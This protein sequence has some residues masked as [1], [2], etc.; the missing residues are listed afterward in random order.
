MSTTEIRKRL[1]EKY[2][3]FVELF[4]RL[5][6]SRNKN[7]LLKDAYGFLVC[8][9]VEVKSGQEFTP[10]D[11]LLKSRRGEVEIYKTDDAIDALSYVLGMYGRVDIQAIC[12]I[13]DRDEAEIIKEIEPLIYLDPVTESWQTASQF[14]SGNVYQ[15]MLIAESR[16]GE[17]EQLLRSYEAIKE[18]QV[19]QIPWNLLTLQLGERWISN[20]H[21]KR[22][23]DW[24]FD[25]S[26]M[27]VS[28]FSSTDTY[29]VVS[30]GS[31]GAKISREYYVMSKGRTSLYGNDL[32]EYALHNTT[33]KLTYSVNGENVPDNDAI[34]LANE[35]IEDLRNK[36]MEWLELLKEE[37]KQ[38]LVD[39]Y[40]NL[41]NCYVIRKY[42]GS[43]LTL[44]GID[45]E[46]LATMGVKEI[47][48]PQ[49]DVAWRIIQ[50][51]GA[52][53]DW[54][55][56]S[57]K[58]ICIVLAAHE[59]KRM[60]IRRKPCI[61]CLKANVADIVRTYRTAYPSAKVLAPSEQDFE[62][63]NRVRLF[64]EMKNNDWD[65][66]IMTHDQ[67][68]RIPQSAEIQEEII[69]EEIDNLD[70]DLQSL[71][72]G[73][74]QVSR[75]MK[76]G[77]ENR[78][79]GLKVK[80]K[81]IK[82]NIDS[83][84]DDDI[85]FESMNI[86]H[87]FI[88]EAHKFKNLTYTTR[89]DRVAGLGDPKGS[90]RALNM[91]FA[92]R[93]LQ[94]RFNS[95][96]QCTFLSG[97]PISNSLTE[98][99]LL[100]KYLRPKELARQN[101]LNFDAWAAVFA[102]K[103][104]DFEFSVTNQIQ[105]KERF[106][107]FIKVPELALFYN[108]IADYKTNKS[109]NIDKP[110]MVEELVALP[111]TDD[112][113]EFIQNL[114]SYAKTGDGSYIGRD[115]L[116]PGLPTDSARMLIATNYAKKMS[117]DMRL[118]DPVMYD[119]HPG[120]KISVCCEKLVENYRKFEEHK[121]VQLVFCDLGVPDKK[122]YVDEATGEKAAKW[123]VYQAMKDK[124]VDE[125]LLPSEQ[126]V[127][128][129]DYNEKSRPTLFKKIR[130]GEIRILLG[131]TDKAGTGVNI[132]DRV[133]TIHDLD[134]PW[135]PAELEQRGGRGARQGNW[136]AKLVQNNVVYRFI[137][138]TEQS[139][140]TYKFTLLKNKQTFISQM[141][142]N[143]LQVRS[144]DE[145]SFDE[146]NGMNFAEYIAVLSGDT[147]L[148]EKA[149][150]DK[151]LAVLEN[152]RV[153]HYREQHNNK[154][155]LEHKISRKEQVDEIV[156]TLIRDNQQYS[157]LLTRDETGTRDNPIEIFALKET[158]QELQIERVKVLEERAKLKEEK[159]LKKEAEKEAKRVAKELAK[160]RKKAG[161]PIEEIEVSELEV[162]EEDVEKEIEKAIP[163]KVKSDA[164]IIGEHIQFL[165]KNWKPQLGQST[166]L[167]GTLYGFN[168]YIERGT[169]QDSDAT[170]VRSYNAGNN[171][172][173]FNKFYV[174][175]SDLNGLK[176]TYNSGIPSRENAKLASRS[177]LNAIDRV[178]V[179]LEQY[180]KEQQG[181]VKDIADLSA[182]DTKPF[183]KETELIALREESKRLTSEI[184]GKIHS[185]T[186]GVTATV[187]K[188][189]DVEYEEVNESRIRY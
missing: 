135:K 94:K 148:L 45:M 35:K 79:A 26:T 184:S 80:L 177:L 90:D 36:F 92:I 163:D 174:Q 10:A 24:V 8:A 39:T 145:G 12:S 62:K 127:F 168:V 53:V 4:G 143:E 117:T 151:K 57:G 125:Y 91:L 40:N 175:H 25:S 154:Y 146:D 155:L 113:K 66:V 134:I 55:V 59:M 116:A 169:N 16:K 170:M 44:P 19:P 87:L 159:R 108:E 162:S 48:G 49:K 50:D 158:L 38:E 188:V 114:I 153:V 119:D 124:L 14:L 81:T 13:T 179:I 96:L 147:T 84:Q 73:N 107:H 104:T 156:T 111:S 142:N 28:Y 56:G 54:E 140:D 101:I 102:K 78:K 131:S 181:L 85:D 2:N 33:P 112:Q 95:D 121:G 152:L 17:S 22:F 182:M 88:D 71:N 5:G 172:M 166:E 144:I 106:R 123:T 178:S 20:E 129:H 63:K 9:S 23:A 133:V 183:S 138:A 105:A 128:I 86:D 167:I 173:F 164:E 72:G 160:E 64:H 185:G 115:D 1:L 141:K 130:E 68:S 15:K 176:Y 3:E 93:T 118:I 97:T 186:I 171:I 77:L 150:V 31:W 98:M 29:K 11:V 161:E 132:Q 74:W 34:Q 99:Y 165:H 43:H 46:S 67:F 65:C 47:R 83:K 109:I 126:I 30:G 70:R 157:R 137:Y 180:S 122:K 136:L 52:I 58:T 76:K 139:L 82:G 21:Y 189:E 69:Q 187:Q 110:E 120:N 7:I 61:L 37:E 32:M 89:H 149:K 51:N 18:V 27:Q 100:F 6:K 41:Y 60:G 75:T 103:T 42:D